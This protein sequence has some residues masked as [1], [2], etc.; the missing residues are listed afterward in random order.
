MVHTAKGF[1]RTHYRL[2]MEWHF[3]EMRTQRKQIHWCTVYIHP[4]LKHQHPVNTLADVE[5]GPRLGLVSAGARMLRRKHC[6]PY[7][8]LLHPARLTL[9]TDACIAARHLHDDSLFLKLY[10][11]T[12]FRV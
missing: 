9:Y 1:T 6:G 4:R 8:A 10:K 3:E 11:K 2:H 7:L 5:S 12:L